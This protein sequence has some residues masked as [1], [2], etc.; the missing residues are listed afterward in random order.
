VATARSA[1][2]LTIRREGQSVTLMRIDPFP[3]PP[4]HKA[5]AAVTQQAPA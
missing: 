3:V 4:A 1:D 5:A 2:P